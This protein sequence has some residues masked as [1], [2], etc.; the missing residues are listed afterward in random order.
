M[1]HSYTYTYFLPFIIYKWDFSFWQFLTVCAL[2]LSIFF[3]LQFYTGNRF[4]FGVKSS[5]WIRYN[6]MKLMFYCFQKSFISFQFYLILILFDCL[7][8]IYFCWCR[9]LFFV[10]F[11]LNFLSSSVILNP[12]FLFYFYF[13]NFY[14]TVD[15]NIW[16]FYENKRIFF[17]NYNKFCF[18]KNLFFNQEFFQLNVRFI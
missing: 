8:F 2:Y 15:W 4:D 7:S 13:F 18:V 11:V 5:F 3:L 12:L 14:S 17:K 9:L 1:I 16:N 10:F 6:L